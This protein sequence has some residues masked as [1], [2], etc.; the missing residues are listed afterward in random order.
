MPCFLSLSVKCLIYGDRRTALNLIV[1]TPD[2]FEALRKAA[3]QI[4]GN[5][6]LHHRPFVDYYYASRDWCK[7]Y[8]FLSPAGG[9]V[10]LVGVER[11][12]FEFDSQPFTLGFGTNFHALQHGIGG[13]LFM[14]W[15][16]SSGL[17]LEYGGTEDA[18]RIIRQQR[19]TY[20]PGV[21]IY[22]LNHDYPVYPNDRVHRRAGKWILRHSSRKRISGYA[23]RASALARNLVTVAEESTFSGDLLPSQSP[24]RFRFVPT[25]EY[26][27]W[28]YNLKLSFAT[29]RLFRILSRGRSAGYVIINESVDRLL[30]AQCDGEDA[31]TLACG[32]ILS[33]L[34]VGKQDAFPRTVLLT[35][36]HPVMAEAYM[37]FGFK[38]GKNDYPMAIGG[39]GKK[40]DIPAD[41]ANWLVNF[42][43]GDN[44]LLGPFLDQKDESSKHSQVRP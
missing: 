39:L 31:E 41:T 33:I 30:V 24:F 9:V 22:T 29:Y 23:A 26:L 36:S 43:W 5:Y 4:K 37:K 15:V 44:G 6:S 13:L 3:S 38:Q 40:V 10:G 18:H 14:Q 16:R 1:Y 35:C 34:E 25:I 12:P 11:M 8:L 21:R 42:D 27:A 2:Q 32:V 17:A 28:R 20:F 7:L 19:W